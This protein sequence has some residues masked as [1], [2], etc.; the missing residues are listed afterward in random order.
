[1][2][3][4]IKNE[5]MADLDEVLVVDQGITEPK[6]FKEHLFSV[7]DE[8]AK[9][10]IQAFEKCQVD[11][12]T[13]ETKESINRR[14][15]TI[16]N[17]ITEKHGDAGSANFI[18]SSYKKMY[19]KYVDI[20]NKIKVIS[21]IDLKERRRYLFFRTCTALCIAV[22]ILLTSYISSFSARLELPLSS[23]DIS[24]FTKPKK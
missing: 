24:V 2:N 20:T 11:S 9:L 18:A 12:T 13:E 6:Q 5:V 4:Q 10:T 19:V 15:Q 22:V 3:E 16:K 1:M 14:L 21:D 23:R 17:Q 7:I 8:S